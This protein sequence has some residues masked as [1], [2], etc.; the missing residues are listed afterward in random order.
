LLGLSG[1]ELIG[2]PL[3]E[4]MPLTHAD[5][6]PALIADLAG[7]QSAGVDDSSQGTVWLEPAAGPRRWVR[8]SINPILTPTGEPTGVVVCFRD[9]GEQDRLV[10]T[11]RQAQLW[12]TLSHLAA[13]VAHGFNN[14]LTV[15]LG[16]CE[17]I[18]SGSLS[19][20]R[21]L[22]LVRGIQDAGEQAA[23]L[24]QHFQAF[25]PGPDMTPEP[26]EINTFLTQL[27]P[28][29]ERFLG[30]RVRLRIEALPA[31]A[32][33]R[34]TARVLK[35]ILF[36]LANNAHE[37]MPEGGDLTLEASTATQN[38]QSDCVSI[39]IRDTGTGIS[40]DV[41]GRLFEPFV[42]TKTPSVGK[43]LGLASV[44]A[45]LRGLGGTIN[46]LSTTPMGTT[47][48][49]VLPEV[50]AASAPAPQETP[51]G[52]PVI[53]V[54][55]DEPGIRLMVQA[56]L[57]PE[58]YRILEAESAE[59]AWDLAQSPDVR[60]DLLLTDVMLPGMKGTELAE[61]LRAVRPELHVIV[62]S[63]YAGREPATLSI[64]QGEWL[65]K[66]FSL[67]D[68]KARVAAILGESTN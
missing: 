28:M 37:A 7:Q 24:A 56:T 10:E 14:V 19:Q 6:C 62:M 13:S 38:D 57:A 65:A 53:L 59:D 12:E 4:V 47:I 25:A 42:T 27:Q 30:P 50:L 45:T 21:I 46:I 43:G 44:Q 63:G 15:I 16:G 1:S 41:R 40:P 33:V 52:P 49:I 17:Q 23:L 34:C 54:V 39:V 67:K 18:L 3:T 66:P 8:G 29:L 64:P 58:G 11:V 31:P 2:R 51:S 60:L 55:D 61:R 48:Q 36:Q 32:Y 20:D 9:A 26:L 5:G 22:T 35:H 68:L